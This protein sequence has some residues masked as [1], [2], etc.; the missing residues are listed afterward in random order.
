MHHM[1]G[2]PTNSKTAG[3]GGEPEV[4]LPGEGS[5]TGNPSTQPTQGRGTKAFSENRKQGDS[6]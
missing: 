1:K 3:A 2:N 4:P 6:P 5:E